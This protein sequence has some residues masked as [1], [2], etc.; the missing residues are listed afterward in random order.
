M[1]REAYIRV[2]SDQITARGADMV[3]RP[4]VAADVAHFVP[5]D[6]EILLR[7]YV[8]SSVSIVLVSQGGKV[9]AVKL[10]P[11]AAIAALVERAQQV[12]HDPNLPDVRGPLRALATLLPLEQLDSETFRRILLVTDESTFGI[13]F[14]AIDLA[15]GQQL[16]QPLGTR[17]DLVRVHHLE[18]YAQT[19]HGQPAA[20]ASVAIFAS[21]AFTTAAPDA[22]GEIPQGWLHELPML[23]FSL[24]EAQVLS[25]LFADHP[26][27]VFLGAAATAE[28]L[29]SEQARTAHILHIS[30]HGYFSPELAH[31]VGLAV[32][33]SEGEAQTGF[34]SQSQL[35]SR[36]FRNALIVLGS[37]DSLQ[38]QRYRGVG[39]Y[40]LGQ[41]LI[42]QGAQVVVG[43]LWEIPDASAA[44]FM[45]HFY[46]HLLASEGDTALAMTQAR[47]ELIQGRVYAHPRHWAGLTLLSRNRAVERR[48][49][50]ALAN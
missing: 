38:G 6:D 28:N 47:A 1:A 3:P 17:F 48:L 19:G 8:R 37:C 22:L 50:P 4:A 29:F 23:D 24:A 14:A 9:S 30:T 2:R 5:A 18:S 42:E 13:P 39:T 34:V 46:R 7:Y 31:I 43:T 16:Y 45:A 41:G 35:L 10:P 20:P 11:L 33:G 25:E 15:Q 26:L 36:P 27:H 49:L 21:P 40:G 44:A 32:A 12:I